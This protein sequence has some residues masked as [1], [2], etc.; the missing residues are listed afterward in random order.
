M[1]VFWLETNQTSYVSFILFVGI[2]IYFCFMWT[3]KGNFIW[4]ILVTGLRTVSLEHVS[5]SHLTNSTNNKIYIHEPLYAWITSMS[6][7]TPSTPHRPVIATALWFP[8]F[9]W[10]KKTISCLVFQT[11][12]AVPFLYNL[13]CMVLSSSFVIY[14]ASF[15]SFFHY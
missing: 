9:V 3:K 2:H 11:S 4:G 13:M 5:V 14:F 6:A 12:H 8:C 10:R 15:I 7:S 1:Y